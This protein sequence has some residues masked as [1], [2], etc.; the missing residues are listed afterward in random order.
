MKRGHRENTVGPWAKT[1]LD[2]LEKYLEFYGTALR[3]QPFERVYIDAFAGA[4]RARVRNGESCMDEGWFHEEP[5]DAEAQEEYILGSPIRALNIRNRFHRYYFFDL[6]ARRAETL[7]QV[8]E[9]HDGVT[10]EVGDCNPMIHELVTSLQQR[11]VRGVAFL[12]PYGPHLEWATL[13]ALAKTRTMEVIINFPVAMAINRLISKSGSVPDNWSSQLTSCFGTEKWRDVAY[14]RET[15]FFGDE[16]V[17][18]RSRVSKRLLDLY[19]ERL[20][21]L[22]PFVASPRLI[23]NTRRAPLYYLIWAGPNRL[24]LKG[25]EHILGQGEP[26]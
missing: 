19:I 5:S 12:D 6:D 21:V 4:C 16:V 20:K 25:A 17:S 14:D 7:R 1:K 24:G 10:I 8:T 26:V 13:D 18:K 23:Q 3:N 11:R 2:A 22:F 9:G 15:D